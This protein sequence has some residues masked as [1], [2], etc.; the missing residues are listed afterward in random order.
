[1]IEART[2]RVMIL[3]QARVPDTKI[4]AQVRWG[5]NPPWMSLNPEM[6]GKGWILIGGKTRPQWAGGG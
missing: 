5:L 2:L 6:T 3:Q 1:M 4:I